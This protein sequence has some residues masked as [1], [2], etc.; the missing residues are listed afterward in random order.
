[1]RAPT[2]SGT[3]A[4]RRP[5]RR[6]VGRVDQLT[7]TGAD[8]S[9]GLLHLRATVD[10]S[11]AGATV[12]R[13]RGATAVARLAAGAYSVTF[14]LMCRTAP[15]SRAPA[16]RGV[17]TTN[18]F[19]ANPR[20]IGTPNE[21]LVVV[22]D[23]NESVRPAGR[24]GGVLPPGDLLD[25]VRRSLGMGGRTEVQPPAMRSSFA[26]DWPGF[27]RLGGFTT[28]AR[29]RPMYACPPGRPRPWGLEAT[30]VPPSSPPG[31]PVSGSTPPA[32]FV[33]R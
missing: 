26:R 25:R 18:A 32:A 8:R 3:I 28:S 19:M 21:G 14:S 27:R 11:A 31:V 23:G 17:T 12:V 5:L 4:R 30:A 15:G 9:P 7:R 33:A 20:G 13:G 6:A 1:V 24:R 16:H 2:R 29:N 22:W 10:T